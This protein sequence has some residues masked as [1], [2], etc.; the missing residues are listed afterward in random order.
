MPIQ[1]TAVRD[2][3]D[4][5]TKL[6]LLPQAD[7]GRMAWLLDANGPFAAHVAAADSL[8]AHVK[9]DDTAQLPR[10]KLLDAGGRVTSEKDGYVKF[11]FPGG[12]N[13]IFS[14]IPVAE[15]DKLAD[16]P[17]V[18]K[19]FL[20]HAG[21][22]LRRETNDVR[23]LFEGIPGAAAQ[24][25]WRHAPQGGAGQAVYC[26]HTEV[27]AKHWLYPPATQ[28][29]WNRPLEFAFG[30]LVLHGESMGCDL[31]PI[32]PAHPRAADAK[33]AM[34]CCVAEHHGEQA[35]DAGSTYYAPS[36]LGRFGAV[37]DYA[38]ESMKRFWAYFESA[39]AL[40]GALTVREKAL[41]ALAV[42]HAKQCP[43]CIDSFTDKCLST[44]AT[45]EA[46]H[47][48]VHVAAAMAAG[49]DLVHGVQMQNALR[50]KGAI[51]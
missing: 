6:S 20:D 8:H 31:R 38:K 30:P 14:S 12:L 28:A 41:I 49:I 32:D 18:A 9:V 46:M 13:L 37:G 23:A 27:S 42:A 7:A 48:A 2:T 50:K 26:C 4:L 17:A 45:V 34:A 25:G 35:A 3:L 24:L 5:A 19:P 15:D 33:A 47:E 11:E 43:Y 51:A 16:E 36:D 10:A 29:D 22:D 44:G 39:T 21:I 1:P 40:P